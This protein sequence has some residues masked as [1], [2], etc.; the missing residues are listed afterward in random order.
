MK[1]LPTPEEIFLAFQKKE[2]RF[3]TEDDNEKTDENQDEAL[4]A[5]LKSLDSTVGTSTEASS[6]LLTP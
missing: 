1:N 2:G 3:N 6:Q 4:L 5:N